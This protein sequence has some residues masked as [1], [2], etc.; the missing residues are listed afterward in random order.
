MGRRTN[1]SASRPVRSGF[2]FGIKVRPGVCG[3][4]TYRTQE[5]AEIVLAMARGRNA[6]G[7]AGRRERRAYFHERCRGWHL[8]SWE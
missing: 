8:T 7:L 3:K 2:E 1:T 5:D 6:D 4:T